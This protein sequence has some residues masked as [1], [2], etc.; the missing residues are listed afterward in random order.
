MFIQPGFFGMDD[1]QLC[2]TVGCL[3]DT[4]EPEGSFVIEVRGSHQDGCA[5]TQVPNIRTRNHAVGGGQFSTR[6]AVVEQ[7]ITVQAVSQLFQS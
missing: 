2:P 1:Y 7:G 4:Q 6:K 5:S 3:L